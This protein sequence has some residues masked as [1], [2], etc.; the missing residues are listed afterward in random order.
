MPMQIRRWIRLF[1]LGSLAFLASV[2]GCRSDAER[3]LAG[4][5]LRELD[6]AATA[7][8]AWMA[9]APS[10]DSA[11]TAVGYLERL[12]L[13]LGSPF[14][15]VDLAQHDPRLSPALRNR[16]SWAILGR[17][18]RGESYTIDPTVLDRA[19]TIGAQS[20]PGIGRA[21]LSLIERTIAN[22]DSGRAA[23][24]GLRLGYAMASA[25]KLV[26]SEAPQLVGWV[27]ALVTDRE[28]AQTD[29]ERLLQAV[30]EQGDVDLSLVTSWRAVRRFG[31]EQPRI[32]ALPPELELAAIEIANDVLASLREL[33]LEYVAHGLPAWNAEKRVGRSLLSDAVGDR[34]LA[35][36]DTLELPPV[37]PIVIVAN[38]LARETVRLPW[39]SDRERTARNRFNARATNEENFVVELARLKP[40]SAH[41][42]ALARAAVQAAVALRA[43]AQE[44]VWFPGMSAPGP[45]DLQE[46]YGL[47][48]VTFDPAVPTHWRP[49]YRRMLAQSLDDLFRVLPALRLD[50]LRVHFGAAPARADA[51]AVHDPRTRRLLLPPAT[52][53]GTIAHEVAHDIDWQTAL[54]RYNVRG[55]YAT[56]RASRRQ[57]DILAARIRSLTSATR[58]APSVNARVMAHATRPAEVFARNVDWF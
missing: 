47:A 17:V 26:S 43:Y 5:V 25:E 10:A 40:E 42:G 48:A 1:S 18:L 58:A 28:L 39:L 14:R 12:R 15:L 16:L 3:R 6:Q 49:Y 54:R 19:G 24:L 46:R 34:L 44:P 45:R 8:S 55:D 20:W 21:H 11:A 35:I 33:G 32:G 9:A 51:L 27:A 23:E 7:T 50:G 4:S 57:D 38:Q 36:E 30:S 2:A 31:V 56:D 53:A 29:A 13:G 22:A 52:A 41:D 37:T